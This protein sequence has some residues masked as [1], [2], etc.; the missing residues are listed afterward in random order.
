MSTHLR[1]QAPRAFAQVLRTAGLCK[2]V[3]AK[4]SGSPTGSRPRSFVY[5]FCCYRPPPWWW[6]ALRHLARFRPQQPRYCFY[7]LVVSVCPPALSPPC[8]CTLLPYLS[9][10][11]APLPCRLRVTACLIAFV[12]PRALLPYRLRVPSC[13]IAF[14]C[15]PALSL[16]CALLQPYRFRVPSSL[17]VFV[18]PPAL[19]PP[20]ALLPCRIRV[21]SSCLIVFVCPRP[22]SPSCA[23]RACRLSVTST[24][25]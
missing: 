9:H 1:L 22:V 21:P 23:L 5:S 12:C 17:I 19:S 3:S 18:C 20:C 15:P 8:P 6:L 14:V 7:R 16:S 11:C 4:K 2:A 10:P 13:L 25:I 24:L